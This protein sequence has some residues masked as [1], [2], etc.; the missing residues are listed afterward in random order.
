MMMGPILGSG[1]LAV[2]IPPSSLGVLLGA[3]GEMSI[4]KVL[5]AIIGPGLLMAALYAIYILVRCILNPSLAPP[6]TVTFVPLSEKL[7]ATAKYILPIGVIIFLVIGVMIAGIATPTEAAATGTL[8][9][10]VLAACYRKLSWSATK[11][12]LMGTLRLTGMIFLILAAS[13]AFSELMVFTGASKG[14]A[15]FIVGLAIPSIL[16]FIV[17]QVVVLILGMFMAVLPIMMIV[18]PIFIPIICALGL[19]PVWFGA[20][21]LVNA[22]VGTISP[23]FGLNLFVMKGVASPDTSTTDIWRSAIPFIILDLMAM[24]LITIFPQIALWLPSRAA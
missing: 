21:F 7:L 8:G 10:V 3:I 4:A 18:L 12:S 23:P 22:E 1:C 17:M 2:M 9:V 16:V 6:Y 13:E 20:V 15:Q 11:K 19:D 14:L 5:L 24:A